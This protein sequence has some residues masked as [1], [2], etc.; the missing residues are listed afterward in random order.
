MNWGNWIALSFV[1]FALFIGTLVTVCVREDISLVAP[2]YYKQEL[3]YQKQIDRKNNSA[4]LTV[5]PEIY[6]QS[7]FLQVS[8]ATLSQIE[9]GELKL[10]RPSN[11]NYDKIFMLTSGK[12]TLQ[13]FDIRAQQGGMYKA[14]MTWTMNGKEYFMEETIYL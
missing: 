7:H 1:L 11:P 6:V 2:D 13:R 12:D 10:F 14:R 9:N 8:F 4:N 5:R 3:D